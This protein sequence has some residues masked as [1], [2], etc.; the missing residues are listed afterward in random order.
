[1]VVQAAERLYYIYQT[2]LD[3]NRALSAAGS[4]GQQAQ[5]AASQHL[6]VR[7]MQQDCGMRC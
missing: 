5:Q 2:L 7:P 1:M 3:T 6:Q 4:E